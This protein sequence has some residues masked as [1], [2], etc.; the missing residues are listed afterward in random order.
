[1]IR[2]APDV[3]SPPPAP[4]PTGRRRRT[5]DRAAASSPWTATVLIDLPEEGNYRLHEAAVDRIRDHFKGYGPIVAEYGNRVAVVLGMDARD[6]ASVYAAVTPVVAQVVKMLGLPVSAAA[7]LRVARVDPEPAR[8]TPEDPG[9]LVGVVEAAAILEVSKQ[10]V[11]QLSQR[12]DFPP[13]VDRL[14]ATPVWRSE[15]IR[16]YAWSRRRARARGAG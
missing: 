7:E 15:E 14:R 5:A 16:A 3:S 12:P 6:V 4:L 1:M 10:R 2:S 11:A 9:S 13:P 8:Q